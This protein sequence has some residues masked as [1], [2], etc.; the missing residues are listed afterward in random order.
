MRPAPLILPLVVVGLSVP[1]ALTAQSVVNPS[2]LVRSTVLVDNELVLMVEHRYE[3]GAVTEEHTHP[4]PRTVYVVEGGFLEF[5]APDGTVSQV[6]VMRGQALWRPAETHAVRNV[7]PTRVTVVETE[8]K[9]GAA[10]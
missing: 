10:P 9:D 5:V 8:L 1:P 3:P 6:E 7:G 2:R 4:G